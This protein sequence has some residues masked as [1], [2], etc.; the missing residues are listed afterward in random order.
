ML[1]AIC[2]ALLVAV[3]TAG[4]VPCNLPEVRSLAVGMTEE[5][6]KKRL[7]SFAMPQPGKYGYAE[8]KH[9][10]LLE[11]GR[12]ESYGAGSPPDPLTGMDTS[13]LAE[14]F[15]AFLDGK[16]VTLAFDY[17][18]SVQWR[19]PDEFVKSLSASLQLPPPNQWKRLNASTLEL[20]CPEHKVRALIVPRGGSTLLMGRAGIKTEI[21]KRKEA[22]R[23]RERRVFKP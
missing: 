10:L 13:N 7:P 4:Q 16:V 9:N 20:T 22:E 21:E 12:Y 1:R 8:F 23:E 14:V 19:N 15:I 3:P 6:I 18:D 5:Q 11:R 17:K 2:V